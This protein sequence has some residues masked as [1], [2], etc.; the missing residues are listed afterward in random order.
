MKLT[1]IEVKGKKF[2]VGVFHNGKFCAVLGNDQVTADSLENLKTQLSKRM[3][4]SGIKL[5][6]PFVRFDDGKLQAGTI[7]GLHAETRALVQWADGTSSQEY[8]YGSEDYIRPEF[9]GE[10]ERLSQ[11]SHEADQALAKFVK[12]HNMDPKVEIR[13]QLGDEG[14][15]IEL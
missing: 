14:K 13:K 15:E 2:E 7:T 12:Q 4:K 6:I 3:M 10:Y 9:A 1:T 5:N 8:T 11:A